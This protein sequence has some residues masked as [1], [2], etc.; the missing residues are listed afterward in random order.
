MKT[1]Y[2]MATLMCCSVL[3]QQPRF[4]L[5]GEFEMGMRYDSNLNVVGL[6]S[7][8][9]TDDRALVSNGKIKARWQADEKWHLNGGISHSLTRYDSLQD[10]NLDITTL[11]VS[12]GFK[13]TLAQFG[14]HAY[15]A[16]AQL[17]TDDFLTYQQQGLSIA[18]H[19]FS[20]GF[21][22][23]SLDQTDKSFAQLSH[24]DASA[25]SMR[26]DG[27]WF[28]QQDGFIN[29]SYEFQDEDANTTALDFVSHGVNLK[30]QHSLLLLGETTRLQASYQIE[31]RHYSTDEQSEFGRDDYRSVMELSIHYPLLSYLDVNLS[32]KR[33]DYDSTLTTADFRET[34]AELS[35]RAHF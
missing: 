1:F 13:S 27:F 35:V 25:H 2:A 33:G 8:S 14:L 23:I 34:V 20:K 31:R 5:S 21:W 15:R 30:V 16:D 6:D 4:N 18:D 10:F 12:G 24:R 22:R 28:Y 19:A 9:A 11:S 32:A 29:L 26:G 17:A 3:A 7:H